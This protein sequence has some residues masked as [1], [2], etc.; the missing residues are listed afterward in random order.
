M[1]AF[2]LGVV[3]LTLAGL[4]GINLALGVT[5]ANLTWED[6][7]R[8]TAGATGCLGSLISLS[9]LVIC[10]G[11]FFS[12]P[13]LLTSFGVPET[14]GQVIGLALGGAVS[15]I[16]AVIALRL[17]VGKVARIGES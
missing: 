10:L 11:L 2:G 8:M 14:A 16:C 6:P 13:V 12:P 1:L 9:Y 7:R 15:L 5:G 4:A 3:A 17:V